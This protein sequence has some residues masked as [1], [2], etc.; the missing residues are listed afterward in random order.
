MTSPLPTLNQAYAMIINEESQRLNGTTLGGSP[1]SDTSSGSTALMSNKMSLGGSSSG[2]E[3]HTNNYGGSSSGYGGSSNAGFNHNPR[4]QY[5]HRGGY[6]R[7]Q[8]VCD[9]CHLK[10]HTKHTCYKLNG[11]PS[12]RKKK[13]GSIS[14]NHASNVTIHGNSSADL[15]MLNALQGSSFSGTHSS[16]LFTQDKYNQIL[17]MLS[18]D[19]ESDA[20]ANVATTTGSGN[21]HRKGTRDW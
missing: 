17:K 9:Y 7:T 3:S 6:G 13:G 8:L 18:K 15:Q 4:M 11:Y 20:S 16:P 2:Y 10:G 21:L 12:D 1:L 14:H 5:E 19:K